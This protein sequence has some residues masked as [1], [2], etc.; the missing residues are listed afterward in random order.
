MAISRKRPRLHVLFRGTLRLLADARRYGSGHVAYI[1]LVEAGDGDAGVVGHEDV[2]R[3]CGFGSRWSVG[4]TFRAEGGGRSV[5]PRA[6]VCVR[7]CVFYD[8]PLNS[9]TI[10][11]ERP[12]KPN[13]PLWLV[14]CVHC[15]G[16]SFS[17]ISHTRT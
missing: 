11:G 7:V 4:G 13:M 3:F 1:L 10:C 17:T 16:A 8:L 2:V 12:R 5:C 14:M 15:P 6:C 9:V